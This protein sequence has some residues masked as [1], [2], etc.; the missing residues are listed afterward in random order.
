ML[1]RLTT[2][3]PAGSG[4]KSKKASDQAA[5]FALLIDAAGL[6]DTTP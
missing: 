4:L 6:R 3:A 1:G 5:E 2:G